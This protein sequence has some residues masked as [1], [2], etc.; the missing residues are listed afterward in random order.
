MSKKNVFKLNRR[1][2]ILEYTMFRIYGRLPEMVQ[3]YVYV[4]GSNSFNIKHNKHIHVLCDTKAPSNVHNLSTRNGTWSCCI[5]EP[6]F[7][8]LVF[9][10]TSTWEIEYCYEK[11]CLNSTVFTV[12]AYICSRYR[13]RKGWS[14]ELSVLYYLNS[15]VCTVCLPIGW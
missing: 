13:G 11:K 15:C 4:C 8:F 7:M 6:L 12:L 2:K 3:M 9:K 5:T 14:T 10:R 1:N